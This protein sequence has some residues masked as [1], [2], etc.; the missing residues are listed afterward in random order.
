VGVILL[1]PV[2]SRQLSAVVSHLLHYGAHA[3]QSLAS[4]TPGRNPMGLQLQFGVNLL[5]PTQD[6]QFVILVTHV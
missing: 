6:K 3:T 1:A 2:H 4:S 5:V